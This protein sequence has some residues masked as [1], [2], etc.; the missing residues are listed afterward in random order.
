MNQQRLRNRLQH[1]LVRCF[2]TWSKQDEIC[3]RWTALWKGVHSKGDEGR[4]YKNFEGV[5]WAA[6]CRV[7]GLRGLL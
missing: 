5:C 6:G 4:G 3:E 2:H 7:V 1:R